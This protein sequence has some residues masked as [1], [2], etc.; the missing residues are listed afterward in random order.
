MPPRLLPLAGADK[1]TID[2]S[3]RD[4]EAYALS[5]RTSETICSKEKLMPQHCHCGRELCIAN[6]ELFKSLSRDLQE[7]IVDRALHFEVAANTNLINEGDTADFI[8]VIR[9]GKVKLNRFDAEGKE[10]I[11]DILL[12]G[13]IIGDESFLW[14][15]H[16]DYNATTTTPAKMCRISKAM[17]FEVIHEHHEA[18]PLVTALIE[19]LSARLH[20][21]NAKIQ[22]LMEGNGLKRVVGFI[23]ERDRR[24]NGAPIQLSLDDIAGST[25]LRRETVSRKLTELQKDGLI[26]RSGHKNLEILDREKLLQIYLET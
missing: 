18:L 17:L 24:L 21:A 9:E 2:V 8:L 12:D 23:L 20:Q 16:F 6:L 22:M 4:G 26:H 15:D 19:Q 14:T 13:E 5:S 25:N 7:E 10:Y 1:A 11:L 3:I